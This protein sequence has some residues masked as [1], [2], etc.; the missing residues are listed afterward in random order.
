MAS[1]RP[2]VCRTREINLLRSALLTGCTLPSIFVNGHTAS[3][4]TLCI[5]H[6]LDHKKL[7]YIRLHCAEFYSPRL[8]FEHILSQL[9]PNQEARCADI[10]TFIRL[11][12]QILHEDY[13]NNTVYLVFEK[14]DRLRDFPPNFLPVFLKLQELSGCKVSVILES[15]IIWENFRIFATGCSEPLCICFSPYSKEDLIEI[16]SS[17]S[18]DDCSADT[19]RSYCSLIVNVFHSST[20]NLRELSYLARMNLPKYLE[21]IHLGKVSSDNDR[22]LWKAIEPHLK[23]AMSSLFLHEVS[24][25][26]WEKAQASAEGAVKL[27][28]GGWNQSVELPYFSK[29]LLIAAYLASYNPAKSD[30]RFFVKNAG[31]MK[32][33]AQLMRKDDRTSS[34][35]LGPKQFQLDRLMAI[36]YSI[37]DG[38]VLP[39]T[40]LH[41]QVS[42]LVALQLLSSVGSGSQFDSPK[43]KCLVNLEFIQSIARTVQFD[44]LHHLYDFN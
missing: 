1:K 12:K 18:P 38:K 36:F 35:V 8:V 40:H 7:T 16:L 9:Q 26:Q 24:S 13:P 23:A 19:Y 43:Y 41:T 25:L 11:L 17:A 22:A 10:N 37:V 44:V 15:E 2:I 14:A 21:P 30:R 4:K 6:C 33:T 32:K 39:T 31:K 27:T 20:R 5:T 28:D 29:Y 3:G 34:Q 42:N